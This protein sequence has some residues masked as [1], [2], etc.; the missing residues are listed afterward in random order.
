M[1]CRH[2]LSIDRFRDR[3]SVSTPR[4]F[5]L[6]VSSL[7]SLHIRAISDHVA[8]YSLRRASLFFASPPFNLPAEITFRLVPFPTLVLRN[9]FYS[10]FFSLP[11]LFVDAAPGGLSRSPI[12]PPRGLFRIFLARFVRPPLSGAEPQN[13]GTPCPLRPTLITEADSQPTSQFYAHSSASRTIVTTPV[14]DFS[15]ACC[16]SEAARG[17]RMMTPPSFVF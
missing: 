5:R 11:L 7:D 8:V 17:F 15:S 14:V 3:V 1:F 4:L 9:S 2:V 10:L 13:H 12:S 16:R 6:V